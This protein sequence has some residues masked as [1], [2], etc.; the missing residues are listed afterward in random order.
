MM[1]PWARV[2]VKED[3]G[4]QIPVYFESQTNRIS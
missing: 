1:A 4:S 3:R 2:A